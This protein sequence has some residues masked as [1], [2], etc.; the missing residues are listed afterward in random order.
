M[1]S[2]LISSQVRPWPGFAFDD[3]KRR[4]ELPLL[5]ISQLERL[6]FLGD[7]VLNLFD[8]SNPISNAELPSGF[9]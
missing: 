3:S 2:A 1:N 4:I 7:G 5:R 6:I 8:Q 9:S